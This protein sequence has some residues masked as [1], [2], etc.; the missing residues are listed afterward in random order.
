M[1]ENKLDTRV[2]ASVTGLAVDKLRVR[3]ERSTELE[4]DHVLDAIGGALD[5]TREYCEAAISAH[6]AITSNPLK[7]PLANRKQSAEI[8][9]KYQ[10]KAAKK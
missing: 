5:C 8:A 7:T 3:Q 9:S 10:Q 6:E 2:P 4:S 1:T